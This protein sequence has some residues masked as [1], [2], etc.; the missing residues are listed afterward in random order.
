MELILD[1]NA[2]I[3]PILVAFDNPKP[4]DQ[5]FDKIITEQKPLY[6]TKFENTQVSHRFF[7]IS[8]IK[9]ID[10]I[11]RL[12]SKIPEAYIADGHHR[13]QVVINLFN[14]GQIGD[15]NSKRKTLLTALFP[16]SDLDIH[17]F[18]R[19]A[20]VFDLCS[21]THF[22]IR[23][24]KYFKIKNL[25]RPAVPQNKFEIIAYFNGEWISLKWKKSI[26]KKYKSNEVLL[27]AELL[28]TYVFKEILEIQ[29][30]SQTT[31]VKYIEGVKPQQEVVNQIN[32]DFKKVAF[33]IYPV[34]KEELKKVAK[35]KLSLPPKS[36]WFEPRLKNGLIA[37]EF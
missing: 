21:P 16:F 24:T 26:L 6:H 5:I 37:S 30:I 14:G 15:I 1:R 28:D 11:T 27:D 19:I 36:T 4:I 25:K 8:D 12:F 18:N 31:R 9:L 10:Q 34:Q 29:D 20:D 17:D 13:R 2:M 22:I 3:K 35:N 7:Q 33:F 23:L 32:A